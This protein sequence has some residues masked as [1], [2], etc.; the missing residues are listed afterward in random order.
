ML[1]GVRIMFSL[2][3]LDY[4]NLMVSAE[5]ILPTT[6]SYKRGKSVC[7][8]PPYT[9]ERDILLAICDALGGISLFQLSKLLGIKYVKVSQ[10]AMVSNRKRFY[11]TR[12]MHMKLEVL[13]VDKFI[14]S[15]DILHTQSIDW[16]THR[17]YGYSKDSRAIR[18]RNT[19]QQAVSVRARK[20]KEP[21]RQEPYLIQA[22]RSFST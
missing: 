15:L 14:N 10:A 9:A 19:D 1:L 2:R 4:I 6:Q 8:A 5:P 22:R 17:G 11:L 16:E 3:V 12:T 20:G 13:L 21:K 7:H 18:Y